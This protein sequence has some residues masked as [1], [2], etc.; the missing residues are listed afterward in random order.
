MGQVCLVCH[1]AKAGGRVT[2]LPVTRDQLQISDY[3]SAPPPQRPGQL[4]LAK[5]HYFKFM[6]VRHPLDRL[7]SAY[8]DKV[9]KVDHK[10]LLYLRKSI[11]NTHEDLHIRNHTYALLR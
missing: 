2:T 8:E 6:F 5:R 10:S 4:E 9:A 11:F 7:I 3:N 1:C